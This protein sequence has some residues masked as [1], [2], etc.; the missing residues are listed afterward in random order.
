MVLSTLLVI[1]GVILT[2]FNWKIPCNIVSQPMKW[3]LLWKQTD[4]IIVLKV[5]VSVSCFG[6]FVNGTLVPGKAWE[7]VW[8]RTE[9]YFELNL[10]L[11]E[12]GIL[13]S[14]TKGHFF[15]AFGLWNCFFEV[16]R[17]SENIFDSLGAC[18]LDRL[19]TGFWGR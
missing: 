1:C 15:M 8:R 11:E 5:V 12:G 13:S 3:V 10:A 6:I 2:S 14:K 7:F 17:W 18:M 9:K 16:K 19:L 4:I